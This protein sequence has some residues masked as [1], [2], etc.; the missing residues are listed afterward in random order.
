[1][2]TD[3]KV[4]C[5]HADAIDRFDIQALRKIYETEITDYQS[6]AAILLKEA[7][8]EFDEKIGNDT[9][10][11]DA[12][13]FRDVIVALRQYYQAHSIKSIDGSLFIPYRYLVPLNI[14]F[15][16]SLQNLSSYY[17]DIGM[18]WSSFYIILIISFIYALYK[19]EQKLIIVT[20]TTLL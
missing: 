4:L 10:S 3:A 5:K 12:Q 14:V 6:Q 11:F 16:W 15:N 7:L 9:L 13:E 19:K 8:D 20:L 18:V 2:N 17:T 1:M